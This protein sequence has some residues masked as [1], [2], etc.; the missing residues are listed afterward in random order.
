[1]VFSNVLV[2]LG[3][4]AL[5]RICAWRTRHHPAA[6]GGGRPDL[7]LAAPDPPAVVRLRAVAEA[8]PDDPVV[9]PGR[10]A[11]EPS[12]VAPAPLELVAGLDRPGCE[13][14]AVVPEELH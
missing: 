11:P 13:D 10:E 4:A 3:P 8:G 6:S 12:A 1:M 9:V 5:K 14:L 2:S 7:E